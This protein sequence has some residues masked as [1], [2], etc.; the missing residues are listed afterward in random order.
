M[1]FNSFNFFLFFPIVIVVYFAFPPRWRWLFLL[2]SSYYFYMSWR[3]DYIILILTSTIID[4]FA[5][6]RMAAQPSKRQRK[7]YLWLSLVANLGLLFS[8]KYF[9]FFSG[10]IQ[11]LLDVANVGYSMPLLQ[12][13]LP[14]GISFY[15]F[16]TLSY[17]IDVYNGKI[18]PE[19][20][21]GIFALYVAYWPQLVAGPIERADR[22]LP[23]LRKQFDFDYER[24]RSG[25]VLILWGLFKKMVIADRIAVYV[26]EVYGS[27]AQYG[28]L[29]AIVA[30]LLF[31]IQIYCDFSGYSD[32]AIGSARVMGVRLMENFRT[33]YFSRSVPEFWR[34]WH[35]SLSTWFR[36]YVY[37]P[38]GG[39]R[40]AVRRWYFN[41]F[42]VF[43]L[44]G[45]W[46]GANW[47]FILWGALHGFYM[48][49]TLALGPRLQQAA[50]SIGLRE[51]GYL[52]PILQ[53]L[54]TLFLVC[55]AW[56]FFRANS[57]GDAFTIIQTIAFDVG[58]VKTVP[59]PNGMT[60]M[61]IS[62][63]AICILFAQDWIVGSEN[64]EEILSRKNTSVRWAYYI[65]I[66]VC[67][68]WFGVYTSNQ[69]IYFQF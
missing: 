29:P 56:I 14:V 30:T 9:N 18:K 38:L 10:S 1:L 69:F 59:L 36:D 45:L 35:I 15:T 31:A 66:I 50:Q 33:P 23:Q 26:N 6:N 17:T 61:I 34:R 5:S 43:L 57:I 42:I 8:F 19:K 46:H 4:Y 21:F 51:D 52:L 40:V 44:S 60:D 28:R 48:L 16:Q 11:S 65:A 7:K 13:L 53:W 63:I 3:T 62:L 64:I 22:L 47:T 55:F 25:L 49:I 27:P 2:A 67:I 41:V 68:M 54:L 37:I 32:I 39:N 12:V 58:S 20:H 24:V